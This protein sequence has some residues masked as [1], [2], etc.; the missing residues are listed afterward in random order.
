MRTYEKKAEDK[1]FSIIAG[2]DEAGRGPLAG[3][4]VSAAVIL[5]ALFPV[6]GVN[7]SKKLSPKKRDYLYENIYEHALSIGIGIVDPVEIDRINILQASLLSMAM[8]VDNLNPQP[9]YL[10]IDGTFRIPSDIRQEPVTHGDGLS[11]SIAAASVV[12]KVTRDRLMERYHRDYPQFGFSSHKG[13]PTRA[14]K[15]AIRKF[16]CCPIHR[17][18]FRG[19]KEVIQGKETSAGCHV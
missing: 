1:G 9:D 4:V 2:V 13:Y 15:E 16:G 3:P 8:S 17:R 12:A 18:S 11:I 5:P 19:V 10:L 14:H 6:S 7:D